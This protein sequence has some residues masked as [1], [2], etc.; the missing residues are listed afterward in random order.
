MIL[1][2]G[3]PTEK[4]TMLKRTTAAI[5]WLLAAFGL[6]AGAQEDRPETQVLIKAPRLLIV[7]IA[8]DIKCIA[9]R[10]W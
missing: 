7:E 4:K 3:P 10:T 2:E 8:L 5:L 9:P 6:P 1:F